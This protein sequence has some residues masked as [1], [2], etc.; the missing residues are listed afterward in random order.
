MTG[1]ITQSLAGSSLDVLTAMRAL[2]AQKLDGGEIA[3]NSI[4]AAY[5]ELREID[6]QIRELDRTHEITTPL[7]EIRARRAK[8][9]APRGRL[10]D[11]G[12]S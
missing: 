2:L 11:W 6:R 10:A 12:V 5:K 7:D 4:A 1:P 8:R 9:H 3:S